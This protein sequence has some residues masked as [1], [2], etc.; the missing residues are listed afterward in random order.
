MFHYYLFIGTVCQEDE[1]IKE[2][3]NVIEE[4]SNKFLNAMDIHRTSHMELSL[5][6]EEKYLVSTQ[7]ALV[8]ILIKYNPQPCGTAL[9]FLIFFKVPPVLK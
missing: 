7:E 2:R 9:I 5:Q 1:R 4:L 3:N 6:A 8:N